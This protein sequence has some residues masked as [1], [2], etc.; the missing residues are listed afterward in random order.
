M[1]KTFDIESR[2]RQR[3]FQLTR[4]HLANRGRLS[5]I[6]TEA[7]VRVKTVSN[8]AYGVTKQPR[9]NTVVGVLSAFG[10]DLVMQ[11]RAVVA[12]PTVGK[13]NAS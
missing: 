5:V 3:V 2:A 9:F 7:G 8:L 6:A 4:E 10:V 12:V 13:A 11:D 1:T